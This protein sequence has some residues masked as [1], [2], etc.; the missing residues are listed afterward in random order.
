LEIAFPAQYFGDISGDISSRRGRPTGT[1]QMGDMQVLKAQAPLAE[2]ADYG[3][4]L[5]AITQGEGFYSMQLS[6][7]EQVPANIAQQVR[8]KA[9]AM[10]EATK[11]STRV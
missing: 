7:Y 9:K 6:H 3:S 2:V 5:K 10:Q 1:D 11:S 4:T 8:E